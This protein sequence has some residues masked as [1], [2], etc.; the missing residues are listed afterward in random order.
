MAFTLLQ[1]GT[2]LQLLDTSGVIV[3]LTL[4]TG[5]TLSANIKPRFAVFGRNVIMVNSPTRPLSVDGN[6]VV[7]VLT[8]NAPTGM[9]VLSGVT[10]GGLTGTYNVKYTFIVIDPVSGNILSES[11]FSPIATPVTITS[12]KLRVSNIS[13]SADAITARRLYRTTNG[14]TTYF[15]WIDLDGNTL[16]T[17]E[18]D[19]SDAG[20]GV[21]AAPNLGSAPDLTLVA[22]YKERLFGVDRVNVDDLVYTETGV[23]YAWAALND[24]PISPLGA[25]AR[26][27]VGLIPR[28]NA[29]GI[30]RRDRLRQLTGTSATDFEI[31]NLDESV[32]M[33]SQESLVIVNDKAYWLWKDGIYRWDENGVTNISNGQVRAWFTTNGWF[34][35]SQFDQAFAHWLQDRNIYRLF[36]CSAG[37]QTNDRFIDYDITTGTWWGPHTT[38]AFTPASVLMRTNSD[39]IP[40]ANIGSTSGYLWQEQATR[41]DDTAT[42]IDLNCDT[43]GH[44]CDEPTLEKVFNNL[45]VAN[46]P[47]TTG[48]LVVTPSVGELNAMAATQALQLDLTQA[49][50]R[51]GHIGRG[52]VATLN[53]Q[54]ATAGQDVQLLGYEID[55]V[56]LGK[57]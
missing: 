23:Q 52:K 5:V 14:G 21:L 20:L 22:N 32:G 16:T 26:G 17:I 4:P 48:R 13:I 27:I 1:G 6:G 28:R 10:S 38:A 54:E 55:V 50:Q 3:S 31:V 36:L 51:L 29:L 34:N 35:R 56:A 11:G 45:R 43:T 2:A 41:T 42:A 44:D 8:P 46:S 24:Q 57:R 19:L 49:N 37:S 40:V 47:Q 7:R 15:H 30:A 53:F 9:P 12:K 39:G 33:S 25:D 18:D